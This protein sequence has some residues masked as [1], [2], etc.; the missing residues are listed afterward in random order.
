MKYVELWSINLYILISFLF[1]TQSKYYNTNC[2]PDWRSP[3]RVSLNDFFLFLFN[4]KSFNWA[5]FESK[6]EKEKKKKKKEATFGIQQEFCRKNQIFLKNIRQTRF[7][8]KALIRRT[9][10]DN[11]LPAK[12]IYWGYINPIKSQWIWILELVP[13]FFTVSDANFSSASTTSAS[14]RWL[15]LFPSRCSDRF[16]LISVSLASVIALCDSLRGLYHLFNQFLTLCNYFS[17]VLDC[18]GSI[19]EEPTSFSFIGSS[20]FSSFQINSVKDSLWSS[21]TIFLFN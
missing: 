13:L 10:N 7:E 6:K 15:S 21:I 8:I 19:I 16:V 20:I 14:F 18:F 1:K 11:E 4:K 5:C 17:T 2:H 3:F 12:R 9:L